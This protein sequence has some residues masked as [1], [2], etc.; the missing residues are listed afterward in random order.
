MERLYRQQ[1]AN[2]TAN[3]EAAERLVSVG[4][5]PRPTDVEPG[6]LAAWT[7]LGNIL[8]NLDEVVTKG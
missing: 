5:S 2:Y 7:A 3:R 6:V 8:L 4:D 1:L